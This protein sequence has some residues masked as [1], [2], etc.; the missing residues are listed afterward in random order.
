M[1]L[2]PR[3]TVDQTWPIRAPARRCRLLKAVNDI[4][5]VHGPVRL[6][7]LAGPALDTL[8]VKIGLLEGIQ[9]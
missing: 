5:E 4:S 8:L 3:Q 7:I 2:V 1:L 9:K 6:V